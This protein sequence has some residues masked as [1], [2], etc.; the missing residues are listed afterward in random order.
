MKD[1]DLEY[2]E[3]YRGDVRRSYFYDEFWVLKNMA[4]SKAWKDI[5]G[6]ASYDSSTVAP[7]KCDALYCFIYRV[8]IKDLRH[9]DVK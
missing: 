6:E 2:I 1:D 4:C 5:A 9:F 8:Y 7:R 3:K